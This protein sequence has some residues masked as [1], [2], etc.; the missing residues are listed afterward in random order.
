MSR[1]GIVPRAVVPGAVA[2]LA[3]GLA[4]GAAMIELGLLASIASLVRAESGVL[5]FVL[6]MLVAAV[7]GAGFGLFVWVQRPAAGEIIYWGLVYGAAWWFIGAVTLLPLLSGDPI[8]WD[9]DSARELLPAL[10]G[11]LVY[12]VVTALAFV[13]LRR[14]RAPIHIDR[15]SLARGVVAGVVGA[16]VLGSVLDDRVGVPAVSA[17]MTDSSSFVAWAVTAGVGIL[18]GLGYG[19]LHPDAGQGMGPSL[20][21]GIAYGFGWWIV[22][23]LTVIPVLAGDGLRWSVE[24]IRAGFATFPGYLLF[25]GAIVALIH[26]GLTVLVRALLSDDVS[27]RAD[28]GIGTRGLRATGRGVVAGLAGGLL[29]TIVMVQIGFLSTVASLVGGESTFLGLVVH[30]VISTIIGV[31]YGLLFVRRSNDAGSALGWGAAYGVFWWLLGPLTLLPVFLGDGPQW[32]VQAANDAYPALV[33]HIAYGALLG[34]A[35]FR[36]E[37]RHDPWW[38]SRSEAEA[39]RADRASRQLLGSAPALWALSVLIALTIPILLGGNPT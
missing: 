13:G 12:G 10:I 16:L 19:A 25:L 17:S 14:E 23:A 21:R 15:G 31:A 6:H 5:G 27:I 20:I 1:P 28:E 11:H 37:S 7:I 3:G 29:F 36:L 38:V 34:A 32:T 33:G 22:A 26:H 9:V 30:L 4:F 35:F 2:G 18:A 8:A 24:D 39:A